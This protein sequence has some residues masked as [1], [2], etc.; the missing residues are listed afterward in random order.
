MS[1]ELATPLAAAHSLSLGLG[2]TTATREFLKLLPYTQHCQDEDERSG[3]QW[4]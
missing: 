3:V 2:T 4:G 1:L